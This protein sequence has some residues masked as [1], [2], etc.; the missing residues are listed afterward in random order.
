MIYL[1]GLLFYMNYRR[2]YFIIRKLE[3]ETMSKYL[4]TKAQPTQLAADL[5]IPGNVLFAINRAL[6]T[7]NGSAQHLIVGE[8]IRRP[9]PTG[10]YHEGVGSDAS[11][12][13]LEA[14]AQQNTTH[15][16]VADSGH[17]CIR[18]VDRTS[19]AS[20][21]VAGVCRKIKWA[22]IEKDGPVQTARFSYI[23]SMAYHENIIYVVEQ[24]KSRIRKVNLISGLVSTILEK[25][26]F[27][28]FD[29]PKSI[30]VHPAREIA[31][32]ATF[33]GIHQLNMTSNK[34]FQLNRG[35]RGYRDGLLANSSWSGPSCFA[36]I[37]SHDTFLI[38]DQ[39]NG[40][41]R[42]L[43]LN[44][45]S[46]CTWCFNDHKEQKCSLEK[47]PRSVAV[48]ACTAY[49]SMGYSIMKLKLPT[50]TCGQNNSSTPISAS[51]RNS[52]S[53]QE[54]DSQSNNDELVSYSRWLV[55]CFP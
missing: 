28:Q 42:T 46:V 30:F 40:K 45:M 16:L 23:D 50:L 51:I 29:L 20:Y 33:S 38:V 54:S 21:H 26:D 36:H 13:E 19:N 24:L 12:L 9:P 31:Y 32:V 11:F 15:V 55:L 14:F 6:C 27:K 35:S 3:N 2:S 1:S 37:P 52:S 7:T 18:G 41:I 22:G 17:G 47:P 4:S 10:T 39:F 25:I 44:Q 34:I 48:V 8:P 53:C 49:F 43:D 5:Y